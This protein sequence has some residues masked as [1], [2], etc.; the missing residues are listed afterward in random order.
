[1]GSWGIKPRMVQWVWGVLWGALGLVGSQGYY[2]VWAIQC[3]ITGGHWGALGDTM[4]P[5]ALV[6]FRGC[7][8]V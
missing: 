3:R 5:G 4:D 7:G 8:G 2:E 1:M 6:I